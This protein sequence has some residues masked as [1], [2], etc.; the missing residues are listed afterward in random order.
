MPGENL[1]RQ[2]GIESA[3]QIHIQPLAGHIGERKVFE[4]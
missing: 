3:N 1:P 4:H 2:V